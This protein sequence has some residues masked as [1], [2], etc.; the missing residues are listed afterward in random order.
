MSCGVGDC[1]LVVTMD[2]GFA[3]AAYLLAGEDTRVPHQVLLESY[4]KS[5]S[6]VIEVTIKRRS[7]ELRMARNAGVLTR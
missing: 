1:A 4:C 7:I 2:A 5:V 6:F 3:R